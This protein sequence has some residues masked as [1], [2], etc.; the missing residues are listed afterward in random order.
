VLFDGDGYSQEWHEE[1][2]RR[3]LKN[4]RTAADAFPELVKPDVEELFEKYGV[5]SKR[6][7]HSRFETYQEQY[8]LKVDVE[9]NLVISMAKRQI[10]PAAIRYQSELAS[11]CANLKLVGYDF[12]TDTLDCV[13]SLV[14]D[15]QDSVGALEHAV[16][17]DQCNSIGDEV[18]H[19]CDV[20]LPSMLAVRRCVDA[21]EGLVADDLWPLPTYQ[22]ML[23]IK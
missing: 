6:E 19:R 10:F 23:F 7:L 22:E 1:A 11:T 4:L 5:L 2:E 18:R 14:K 8:C 3:G 9:A 15:L 16:A 20:V 21:L 17:D 12:D 13:T